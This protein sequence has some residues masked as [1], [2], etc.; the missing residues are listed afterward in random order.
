VVPGATVVVTNTATNVSDKATTNQTG[1]FEVNFLNPGPYSVSVESAGFKKLVR[2]GISVSTGDRLDLDL[3]LE[4][5]QTSQSVEVSADAPLL[6]TTN[7]ATGRVLNTRDI[8][9]L[10]YTTMNPFALQAMAAGMIFTG[11]MTPD[12]NRALDHAA[13]ASYDSG[14]LGTG[15]N[16][17]LLDGNPVTGTNGGRAGFVPNAEAVDEV[18]IE[19]SP[20]D[21]SMGHSVGSFISATVKSGTNGLHGAGFWQFQQFRWNAAPHFT[22]L[23]YQQGL[24]NGSIAPG[25]PEQAS[26]R[27]TTPG[28]GVGGPVWIPKVIN[29]K[30]KLF[31]YVSYSKL[32][33]IASPNSTP[34]YTVPTAAQ[35]T[36]DF[37]ALLKGTTNPSQYIVYDP[38]TAAMVS[39]HVTRTP[40]PNNTV[41]ASMQ[42]NPL[43]KFW[44][45][46]WPMP[47]NPS[48]LQAD[49]TN[50]FY[51]GGPA[52]QR[53]VPEFHQPLRLQHQRAAAPQRQVVLQLAVLG[54]VRLGA[55]HTPEGHHVERLV[56][57]HPR[58]QPG[59]P[60]H[61]QCQQRAGRH[62][63]HHSIFGRRQE[64]ERLRLQRGE[65]RA[66]QLHRPEGRQRGRSALDQCRRRGRRGFHQF[67]GRPW[68]EPAR[69]HG[70]VGRQDDHHQRQAYLQVRRGGAALSLCLGEPAGQ[71]HGVLPV[72]Q[73]LRQA[74]G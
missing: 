29:G 53:L 3:Q 46:I 18:R 67:R 61:H 64:A 41:P 55:R 25:T 17:F 7:A 8:G 5:G 28:F 36:G 22:R 31:F 23:N 15:T 44:S 49:G 34:I 16:E 37:S 12:N 13:T 4:I 62:F 1:Y 48:Q 42:T 19:T 51:D 69:N 63:Q 33:S 20:Y 26:G 38:R 30:N 71:P 45:Q 57:A 60:V 47:N 2:S 39:S 14:G 21:A 54:S 35:R 10:P 73:Q 43:A 27:V 68:A 24:A 74:G 6:D 11:S 70:T 50:N 32:V 65:G 56:A 9:Q 58:G 66:A 59:L 52:E 40:F 72:Q